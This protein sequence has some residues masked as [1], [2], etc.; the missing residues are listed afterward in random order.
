[1]M[2]VIIADIQSY[3]NEPSAGH[4]LRSF[5]VSLVFNSKSCSIEPKLNKKL[6][7]ISI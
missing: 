3:F 4:R 2:S 5:L 1:M 7:H 6:S